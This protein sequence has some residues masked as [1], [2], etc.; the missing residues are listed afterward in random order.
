MTPPHT[1]SAKLVSDDQ[2]ELAAKAI[3]D[4]WQFRSPVSTPAWVDRGN[5]L[6]QDRAR[7]FARAALE[8][9]AAN[10]IERHDS[11]AGEAEQ[12]PAWYMIETDGADFDYT[13]FR[14]LDEAIDYLDCPPEARPTITP[15]YTHPA[16][17]AP[18]SD[19]G[20]LANH[21]V[22]IAEELQVAISLGGP[23]RWNYD[24]HVHWILEAAAA[25]AERGTK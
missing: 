24:D 10:L 7:S 12:K 2:I 21:L 4:H 18:A 11:D 17:A 19:G 22:A 20:E 6:Q 15:L 13:F 5:S 3:Y 16:P 9:V 14:T 25:L 8:A 1:D 23:S